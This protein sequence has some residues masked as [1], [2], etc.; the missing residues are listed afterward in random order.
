MAA[1]SSS[2]FLCRTKLS[3]VSIAQIKSY[4]WFP[5]CR[6]EIL[7]SHKLLP[8]A[9]LKDSSKLA[10]LVYKSSS[11]RR[12]QLRTGLHVASGAGFDKTVHRLGHSILLALAWSKVRAVSVVS[13][14]PRS[15][16]LHRKMPVTPQMRARVLISYVST[17]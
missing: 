2:F 13:C 12:C 15:K 16:L 6:C 17:S 7:V 4:P 14:L 5:S 3:P 9:V 10:K 1:Y 11:V 8:M